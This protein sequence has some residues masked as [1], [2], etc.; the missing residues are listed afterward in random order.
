MAKY[1]SKKYHYANYKFEVLI[2]L[3]EPYTY[4]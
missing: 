1:I 3:I 2:Y 4:L